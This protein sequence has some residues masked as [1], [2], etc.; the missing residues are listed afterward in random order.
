MVYYIAG[1][2]IIINDNI[3]KLV[4]DYINN[5]DKLPTDLKNKPIGEWN[6][7]QVTNMDDLFRYQFFN[8]SIQNW[9]VENVV[10][11]KNMFNQCT[12]F[13]KPLN[14]N[15]RMVTNMKGMFS[16]YIKCM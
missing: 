8:E 9:N 6:V 16:G 14:W 5:K 1:I 11:M 2:F 7:T 15:V 13:N 4:K 12:S 10:T 3:K